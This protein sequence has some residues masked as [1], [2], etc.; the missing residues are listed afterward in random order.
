MEKKQFRKKDNPNSQPVIIINE[1][2]NFVS[3]S[4]GDNVL[5]ERFQ[6][7]YE[8][9]M[10]DIVDPKS[11]LNSGNY[12]KLAG[13]FEQNI[14]KIDTSKITDQPSISIVD[15]TTGSKMNIGAVQEP[16]V[17]K[18]DN[19][20]NTVSP[21]EELYRDEVAMYGLNEANNRRKIRMK[22][23]PQNSTQTEPVYNQTGTIS[24]SIPTP[25]QNPSEMIF[26][27]FKRNHDITINIEF[28]DKI[29]SPDFVKMM[30]ENIEGDI[31]GYYKNIIMDNIMSKVSEVENEVEYQIIKEIYGE[32]EAN[33]FKFKKDEPKIG[34]SNKSAHK[35]GS[36]T[37]SGQQKF[38]YYDETG[39][40][41]ELLPKSA[42][43]KNLKPV[44]I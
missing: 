35:E 28:K 22:R 24:S 18:I 17:T 1:N 44:I 14:K 2:E 26:K 6:L 40:E 16:V 32:E 29:G 5:T 30:L 19:T 4:N 43:K 34:E 38:F 8:E 11:F 42:E 31:I 27:S 7:L 9:L 36:V 21:E 39:K 25:T 41:V 23:Q 33:K 13:E 10:S 3:L 15:K 20:K 12:G 37:K